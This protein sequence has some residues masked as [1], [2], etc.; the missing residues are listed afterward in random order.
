MKNYI[1]RIVSVL[2]TICIITANTVY[3]EDAPDIFGTIGDFFGQVAEDT[4]GLAS[5]A[6]EGMET[7]RER[8]PIWKQKKFYHL[9]LT[10]MAYPN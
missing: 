4:A 9:C 7:V 1:R 8:M 5:D 2:L 3:G 10:V 6:W